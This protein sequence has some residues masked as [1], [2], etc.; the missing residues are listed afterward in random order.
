[1]RFSTKRD[2]PLLLLL[3]AS[4]WLTGAAV[5]SLSSDPSGNISQANCDKIQV[6]MTEEEVEAILGE[7][8]SGWICTNRTKGKVWLHPDRGILVVN[9]TWGP[10]P[11]V[12]SRTFTPLPERHVLQRFF[13]GIRRLLSQLGIRSI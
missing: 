3:L 11:K 7:P 12:F 8:G 4:V 13:T 6:G 1:M 10:Q 2:H 9:F 5:L